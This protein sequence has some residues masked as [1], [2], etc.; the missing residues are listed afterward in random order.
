MHSENCQ[1]S[2]IKLSLGN[3]Q[4]LNSTSRFCKKLPLRWLKKPQ[5]Q[6]I[7]DIANNK[8]TSN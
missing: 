4:Q 5:V 7:G 1:T 2:K 8:G 6:K 3:S